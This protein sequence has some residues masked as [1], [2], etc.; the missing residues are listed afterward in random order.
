MEA[1]LRK[2]LAEQGVQPIYRLE[3]VG[4]EYEFQSVQI[5]NVVNVVLENTRTETKP[6]RRLSE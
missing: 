5:R 2:Q 1:V 3:G 4:D 6:N